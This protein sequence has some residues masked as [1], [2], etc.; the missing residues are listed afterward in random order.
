MSLKEQNDDVG[1]VILEYLQKMSSITLTE[2]NMGPGGL[3]SGEAA[4]Y[5][6]WMRMKEVPEDALNK[7]PAEMGVKTASSE[8]ENVFLCLDVSVDT[9]K[10]SMTVLKALWRF[11]PSL[12]SQ[13]DEIKIHEFLS[14]KTSAFK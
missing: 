11:L 2:T 12:C 13:P 10:D 3:P 4:P 7:S 14:L 1:K 5:R 6:I 8:N 9:N